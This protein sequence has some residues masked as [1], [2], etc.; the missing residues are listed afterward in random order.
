M[1]ALRGGEPFNLTGLIRPPSFFHIDGED[2]SSSS[3]INRNNTGA[4]IGQGAT[5]VAGDIHAN[6]MNSSSSSSPTQSFESDIDDLERAVSA[7]QEN[8]RR[9]RRLAA[10]AAAARDGLTDYDDEDEKEGEEDKDESDEDDGL[11]DEK[12]TSYWMGTKYTP[13]R[14]LRA[15]R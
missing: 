6:A 10:K 13:P 8:D 1:I 2:S 5:I 4:K 12:A 7:K 11:G 14:F 15:R 9:A 3:R